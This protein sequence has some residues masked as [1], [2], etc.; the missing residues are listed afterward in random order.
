MELFDKTRVSIIVEE[1][2]CPD[3]LRLIDD[4]GGSGY[5]V[6]RG[7]FGRGKHGQRGEYGDLDG[8]S[9]NVEVVTIAGPEVTGRILEG[10]TTLIDKGVIVIVHLADVRV[11]RDDH[12]A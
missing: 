2:F 9:G 11:V 12:F 4:S 8:I 1:A 5:T 3:V 7:I 10:I 6:Y